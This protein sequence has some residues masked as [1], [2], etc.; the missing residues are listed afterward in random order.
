MEIK[1]TQKFVRI[2]P[3]KLRFVADVARKMAPV[4]AIERL[5]FIGKRAAEPIV[6]VIKT[7]LANAKVKGIDATD[8]VFKELQINEGPRLKRGRP[9]SRGRWHPYKR[10]M[11]HIRVVL[12]T[13]N[14]VISDSK[15]SNDKT[16]KLEKKEGKKK[17]SKIIPVK[18][19]ISKAKSVVSKKGG[20]SLR[21]SV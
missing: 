16:A 19:V 10:R 1:A 15:L 14:E 7:A 13:R 17:G 4:D 9:V 21:K 8:L 2:S 5:S 12:T 6:R 11:S 3:K 20:S 18:A